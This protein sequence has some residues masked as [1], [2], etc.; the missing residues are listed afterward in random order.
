MKESVIQSFDY[1]Q[2][3]TLCDPK[4]PK[5]KVNFLKKSEHYCIGVIDIVNSSVILS[6]LTI[7]EL[8][9]YYGNF[10]NIMANIVEQNNGFVIKNIGDCLLFYFPDFLETQKNNKFTNC[11]N[12]CS[13][14]TEIHGEIN[15]L[16]K[17]LGLPPINYRISVDYGEVS[18]MKTNFSPNMD[19]FGNPVNRCVKINHL[20]KQNSA[21]IGRDLY[22]NVEKIA[23]F[24][25]E[26]IGSYAVNTKFAYPVYSIRRNSNHIQ[27]EGVGVSV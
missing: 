17:E 4:T 19:L 18:I 26:E 23:D 16:F 8:E 11:L 5:Y 2:S 24:A 3:M 9:K 10:L 20:A 7:K 15:H 25:Y 1:L 21:V 14:M 27:V 12:C 6:S 13:K 22:R